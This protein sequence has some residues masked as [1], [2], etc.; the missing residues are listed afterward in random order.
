MRERA[1]SKVNEDLILM[2]REI[3]KYISE[4]SQDSQYGD[5][6][7][8]G[9]ADFFANKYPELKGF[10]WCGLY[11]IHQFYE[12][13]KDDEK[14]STQLIQL[15]WSNHLKIMS[16]CKSKEGRY[17]NMALYKAIINKFFRK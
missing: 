6:F 13:Y 12:L 5:S 11:R 9:L 1:F 8:D 14:V 16:A 7:V 2:Y 17:F 3:G 10:T 4:K 15:S